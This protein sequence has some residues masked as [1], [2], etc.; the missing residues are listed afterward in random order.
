MNKRKIHVINRQVQ[1]RLIALFLLMVLVSLLAFSGGL[2]IYYWA[3]YA[4]GDNLFKEIITIHK[5]VTESK[6]VEENGVKKTVYYTTT[7]DIP[8]VNRLELIIPPLLINDIVIMVLI[9]IFG[10]YYTNRIAGPAY[11]ME[12]DIARV[13]NGEKG[14]SVAL[15]K[16]DHFYSLAEQ[17]NKLIKELEKLQEEI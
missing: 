9:S 11:R 16:H 14:V 10:I 8:G 7:K 2:A 15:R 5:Q 1:Y 6:V 13:L 3:S 17:V 12:M 4:A